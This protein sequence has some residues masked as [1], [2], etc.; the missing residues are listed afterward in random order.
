MAPGAAAARRSCPAAACAPL[1]PATPTLPAAQGGGKEKAEPYFFSPGRGGFS[2][3]G[4]GPRSLVLLP[5]PRCESA[6]P[7]GAAG[8]LAALLPLA[9]VAAAAGPG[10]W[11]RRHEYF[12]FPLPGSALAPLASTRR[13]P[14]ALPA[15]RPPAPRSEPAPGVEPFTYQRPGAR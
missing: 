2:R 10:R 12:S 13:P 15:C 4:P 6:W 3:R 1:R 9:A 7:G 14:I 11:L 8:R 5:P